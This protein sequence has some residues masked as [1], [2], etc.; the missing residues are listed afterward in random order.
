VSRGISSGAF[1][2]VHPLAAY[3]SIVVPIVVYLAATPIRKEL[4]EQHLLS[5]APPTPEEFVSH[6]QQVARRA[7]STEAPRRARPV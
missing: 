1:R 2:H 5:P 6:M 7:L 4:A 3:F